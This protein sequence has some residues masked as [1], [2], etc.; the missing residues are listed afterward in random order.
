MWVY[1][2]CSLFVEWMF[3]IEHFPTSPAINLGD[4]LD[5]SSFFILYI[6]SFINPWGLYPIYI[7]EIYSFLSNP[8][9]TTLV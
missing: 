2:L 8:M 1:G 9:A 6:K 3:R 4:N 5:F 7:Y